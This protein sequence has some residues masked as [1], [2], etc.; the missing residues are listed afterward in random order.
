M[1]DVSFLY[2]NF[3]ASYLKNVQT[4]YFSKMLITSFKIKKY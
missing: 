3:K 2:F 4:I 1:D